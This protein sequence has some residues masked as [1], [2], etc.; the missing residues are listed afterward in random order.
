MTTCQPEL[1]GPFFDKTGAIKPSLMTQEQLG[2][3]AA[4]QDLIGE[5]R[6]PD[7]LRAFT[8]AMEM[9]NDFCQRSRGRWQLSGSGNTYTL[10]RFFPGSQ[11]PALRPYASGIQLQ[12]GKLY[13]LVPGT[14]SDY[15]HNPTPAELTGNAT[16]EE[17]FTA[18]QALLAESLGVIE[19]HILFKNAE[20]R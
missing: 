6:A 20:T 14:W 15:A 7:L 8:V 13:V 19:C 17:V 18:L 4:P 2:H 12:D 9:L 3:L 16:H 11:D 1:Y 10:G 5:E